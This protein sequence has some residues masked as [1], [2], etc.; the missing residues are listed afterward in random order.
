M[1]QT[2]PEKLYRRLFANMSKIL[3]A[4]TLA[5]GMNLV[6]LTLVA[7]T[8]GPTGLGVLA[9]VEAYGRAVQRLVHL[10]PWQALVRYGIGALNEGRVDDLKRLVKFCFLWDT[11]SAVLS[12]GVALLGIA[13]GARLLGLPDETA[14]YAGAFA[15]SLVFSFSSSSVAILRM[16]DRFGFI[17]LHTAAIALFR[18]GL[19]ALAVTV[20][21]D[22]GTFVAV[23]VATQIAAHTTLVWLGVRELRARGLAD[24]WRAPL[25]GVRANNPGLLRLLVNSNLNVIA[26][27]STDR[28]DVLI[29]GGLVGVTEAGL[30]QLARRIGTAARKVDGPLRQCL[31]PDLA[32]LSANGEIGRLRRIVKTVNGSIFALG[33]A[34]VAVVLPFLSALV[35]TI[36]GTAFLPATPIVALQLVAAVIALSGSTLNPALLAIGEDVALVV[37]SMTS[38]VFFFA[39]LLPVALL[40]GVT[41]AATAHVV[42]V[43]IWAVAATLVF[44]RRT[45][46]APGARPGDPLPA[47]DA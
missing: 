19:T 28:F 36:F 30:Y 21:Q 12:A 15:A 1:G 33:I 26:R 7:R 38:T 13:I 23:L 18:L 42:S 6:T 14:L 11:A 45:A 4:N 25:S 22:I 39:I 9:L 31:F 8:L 16:F 44:L 17:A 40:D 27:Q 3:S 37:I 20:S 47:V 24:A 10:E 35:G 29:V 2:V 46:P 34:G 5:T 43:G 41:W 32:R